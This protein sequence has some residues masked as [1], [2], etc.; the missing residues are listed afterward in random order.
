LSTI[1]WGKFLIVRDRFQKGAKMAN[2]LT[3]KQEK[4][5]LLFRDAI[6]R[7]REAQ[8]LYV[9]TLILCEDP[10]LRGIIEGFIREEKKHEEILIEKYS[11]LR[12]TEE[13]KDAT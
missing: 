5:L 13:F 6:E 3:G 9:E 8:K 12:N 1:P 4:M 7:E 2:P 10:S 11:E